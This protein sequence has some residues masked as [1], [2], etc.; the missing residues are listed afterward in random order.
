MHVCVDSFDIVFNNRALIDLNSSCWT[1]PATTTT[2]TAAP[3]GLQ[4]QEQVAIGVGVAIFVLMFTGIFLYYCCRKRYARYLA[5]KDE[6]D[7]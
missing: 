4:P 5:S 2:T 3:S 6:Y 7:A 1:P